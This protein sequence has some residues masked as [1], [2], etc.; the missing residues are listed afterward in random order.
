MLLYVQS[1]KLVTVQLFRA[2]LY[3]NGTWRNEKKV[4]LSL[5]DEVAHLRAAEILSL[6]IFVVKLKLMSDPRIKR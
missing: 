4:L 2:D 3:E 1:T 6:V 5:V